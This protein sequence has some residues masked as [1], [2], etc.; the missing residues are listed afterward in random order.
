MFKGLIFD[1]GGVV[2]EWSNLATYQY[3]EERYAYLLGTLG[4]SLRR[5]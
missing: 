4:R 3:I 1:L 2:V 5:V